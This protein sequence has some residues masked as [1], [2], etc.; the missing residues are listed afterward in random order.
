MTEGALMDAD[1]VR[2]PDLKAIDDVAPATCRR[3]A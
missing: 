1:V 3:V 2:I